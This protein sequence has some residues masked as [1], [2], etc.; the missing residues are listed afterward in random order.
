MNQLD[1]RKMLT[2]LACWAKA[3]KVY[4]EYQ[5]NGKLPPRL[6]DARAEIPKP[7]RNRLS[8]SPGPYLDNWAM[9]WRSDQS[10]SEFLFDISDDPLSRLSCVA[11]E[12]LEVSES[13]LLPGWGGSKASRDLLALLRPIKEGGGRSATIADLKRIEEVVESILG[14]EPMEAKEPLEGPAKVEVPGV[15]GDAAPVASVALVKMSSPPWS[16]KI[17][18]AVKECL[19]AYFDEKIEKFELKKGNAYYNHPGKL[20]LLVRKQIKKAMESKESPFVPLEG[21]WPVGRTDG[22][23]MLITFD[24]GENPTKRG[25]K[26]RES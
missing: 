6:D 13:Q 8:R 19:L 20:A 2:V 4:L 10:T 21:R 9:R 15:G 23:V 14:E 5:S 26:P 11:Q 1:I 12:V 3:A 24:G 18:P 17:A 7:Y 22:K 25:R 16:K